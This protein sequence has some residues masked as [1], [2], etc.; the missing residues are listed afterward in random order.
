MEG[1]NCGDRLCSQGS[2]YTC[3][4][5]LLLSGGLRQLLISIEFWDKEP[6]P[7]GVPYWAIQRECWNAT[8]IQNI[9]AAIE[10]L[11]EPIYFNPLPKTRQDAIRNLRAFSEEGRRGA[12]FKHL[13]DA[14]QCISAA[15]LRKCFS[16]TQ[17][18]GKQLHSLWSC[19][20]PRSRPPF[21][22]MGKISRSEEYYA[23]MYEFIPEAEPGD[24][25]DVMQPQIHLLW[26]AGFSLVTLRSENFWGGYSLTWRTLYLL[27]A[28]CGLRRHMS[29]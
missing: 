26:L 27:R 9:R 12:I 20:L 24:Y 17:V 22:D 3:T 18:S 14:V 29:G 19:M 5:Y 1:E 21:E 8:L 7:D 23:I 15:G 10:A 16:W 25:Y 11:P 2:M 4:S 13:P 28:R 6:S